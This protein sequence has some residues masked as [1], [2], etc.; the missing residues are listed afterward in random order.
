MT[1]TVAIPWRNRPDRGAVLLRSEGAGR[2]RARPGRPS[3][4]PTRCHRRRALP[5][6]TSRWTFKYV[7]IFRVTPTWSQG[8]FGTVSVTLRRMCPPPAPP[9]EDPRARAARTKRDRTR[10]ALIAAADS[11]FAARGWG[12]TRVED[13]AQAAGVSPA[14]A[15]NHFPSKHA[16]IG[17]VYRP[18]VAPL[19]VQAQ[20]DIAG[21][22]DVLGAIDDQVRE[23]CRLVA[24]HRELTAAFAAGVLDYTARVGGPP[25]PGDDGDPRVLAP[26]P[27]ALVVLVT[28]GQATGR[29][30]DYP[31]AREI[32]GLVVNA[33]LV[34]SVSRRGEPV[35]AMAELMLTLLLGTLFPDELAARERPYRHPR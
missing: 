28:H 31:P 27:E 33:L 34:R 30:R 10:S 3:P 20:R 29:L 26:M 22:R 13:I 8:H 11:A 6:H 9:P 24:R 4:A 19:L 5:R 16:L 12:R 18:I 1:V 32:C 23:L 14:S 17:A 15:Y 25:D 21:G 35:P 2:I 7:H